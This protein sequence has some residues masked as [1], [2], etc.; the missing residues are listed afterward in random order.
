MV[1]SDSRQVLF[2]EQ[3]LWIN[4]QPT[5]Y[6]D[7]I[8]KLRF[9]ALLKDHKVW[10]YCQCSPWTVGW[11]LLSSAPSHRNLYSSGSL[12]FYTQDLYSSRLPDRLSRSDWKKISCQRLRPR[13]WHGHLSTSDQDNLSVSFFASKWRKSCFT[14]KECYF[15]FS[16]F[17]ESGC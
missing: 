10:Q 5:K 17:G 4:C 15:Q 11:S 14:L 13:P 1:R 16:I 7:S 6:R 9:L 8:E 3:T 12:W 2:N